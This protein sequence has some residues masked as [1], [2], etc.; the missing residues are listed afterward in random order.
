MSR[1]V[2]IAVASAL[3]AFAAAAL[4]LGFRLTAQHAAAANAVPTARS[5]V[6]DGLV[7]M[8]DGIENAGWGVH[9]NNATNWVD[10]VGG[11]S[12]VGRPF[13]TYSDYTDWTLTERRKVKCYDSFAKGK[14]YSKCVDSN[15]VEHVWW[16]EFRWADD[17]LVGEWGGTT[18][19]VYLD[20]GKTWDYSYIIQI[21]DATFGADLAETLTASNFTIEAVLR[22]T[23]HPEKD[24][25]RIEGWA[26]GIS[27]GGLYNGLWISPMLWGSVAK[28]YMFGI[29]QDAGALLPADKRVKECYDAMT[30]GKMATIVQ[31]ANGTNITCSANGVVKGYTQTVP[32]TRLATVDTRSFS[33]LMTIGGANHVSN[34]THH[35]YRIYNR[36]LTDA[37]IKHNYEID[38]RR[39]GTAADAE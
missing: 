7:A 21:A 5:Y 22:R 24:L 6:Q 23:K 14:H 33:N 36:P 20:T 27:R 28:N 35:C 39:F 26:G 1:R 12:I 30:D 11:A 38:L 10:L 4:P 13:W 19:K 17:A 15:G 8:W 9:D 16:S 18:A 31:V 3:A 25:G 2:A 29:Q 37:E 34:A 32:F